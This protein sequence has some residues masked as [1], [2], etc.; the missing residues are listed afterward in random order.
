[1][2]FLPDDPPSGEPV[3]FD[4]PQS[5]GD[6]LT[7]SFQIY[8]ARFAGLVGLTALLLMPYA[9]IAG[10][11][12]WRVAA[13]TEIAMRALQTG[14]RFP[15]QAMGGHMATTFLLLLLGLLVNAILIPALIYQIGEV[16]HGRVAS[17]GQSLRGGLSRFWA[18]VGMVIAQGIVFALIGGVFAVIVVML[19]LTMSARA[20]P[21]SGQGPVLG[22]VEFLLIFGLAVVLLFI[23]WLFLFARWI[24]AMPALVL[25]RRG[26]IESLGY[27]WHLTRWNTWRAIG[28]LV[29]LAILGF[30]VRLPALFVQGILAVIVPPNPGSLLAS[31]MIGTMMTM[32]IQILWLPFMLAAST[33]F[34]YDLRARKEEP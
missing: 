29:L 3:I 4:R 33:L 20:D 1:M 16:L 15:A 30:I 14:S 8:R 6:L 26:P 5:I 24:A 21:T 32:F 7:R 27:S 19:V 18:Y 13:N 34:Y 9:L 11:L 28:F 31:S 2:S 22:V 10:W 25:E 23:P 17:V 12:S